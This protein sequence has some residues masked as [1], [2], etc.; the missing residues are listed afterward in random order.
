MLKGSFFFQRGQ[1][2]YPVIYKK[3]CSGAGKKINLL[4]P[5]QTTICCEII[6]TLT[7][8]LLLRVCLTFR[9]LVECRYLPGS[10]SVSY[11]VKTST[12]GP[13]VHTQGVFGVQL[14]IAKGTLNSEMMEVE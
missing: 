10:V 9:L 13:A 4:M 14:R 11:M 7:S 5:R 2:A 6:R 12:L 8:F 3:E 1:N